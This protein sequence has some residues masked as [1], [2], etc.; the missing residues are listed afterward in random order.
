MKRFAAI[1][2]VTLLLAPLLVPQ[3]LPL[4]GVQG[5]QSGVDKAAKAQW[6][7][8]S[9]A[10]TDFGAWAGQLTKIYADNFP[11]RD[12]MVRARN[13]IWMAATGQPPLRTVLK[14]QNGW[15]FYNDE[16]DMEDW[17]GL[18]AYDEEEIAG[19]VRTFLARREWLAQRGVALLVVIAPNKSTVYG[20]HMPVGMRRFK[21]AKRLDRLAEAF[22]EAGIPFLDLRPALFAAKAVRQ[23]Y[24]KTDTHWNE[25]GALVGCS[26]I[27]ER[28]RERFPAMPALDP[29]GYEA[30]PVKTPGGDLPG[31]LLLEDLYPED[32]VA[33]R[34]RAPHRAKDA[35]VPP[36]WKDPAAMTAGRAAII[37]TIDDPR[38]PKAVIF[39]DS[40]SQMAIPFL[41]ERFS[42]AVYIWDHRFHVKVVIAE[43]P[44]VV[45]YE[46]V[47][48]YQ[49]AIFAPEGQ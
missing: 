34:P 43:K 3:G 18:T 1:F 17:M 37:K 49:H 19:H 2:A 20:E 26:A 24:W 8:A 31:M 39:R 11:L 44:D 30:L 36:T 47:E 4:L 16:M 32:N 38:L 40:F 22:T 46:A 45:I 41:S 35:P 12:D 48:R 15:W 14:G 29:A 21:E 7:P 28:L 33:M 27:V 25:W 10:L 6:P 13:R 9:L 5:R 23:S 42:R